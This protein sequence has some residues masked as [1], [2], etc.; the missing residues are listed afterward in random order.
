MAEKIISFPFI[1]TEEQLADIFSKVI[2]SS[3]HH[4]LIGKL[5]RPYVDAP[6]EEECCNGPRM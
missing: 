5:G 1:R 2:A 4:E 3:Q 6:L